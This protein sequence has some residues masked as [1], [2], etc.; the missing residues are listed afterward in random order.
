[1]NDKTSSP[2][3][4]PVISS[5]ITSVNKKLKLNIKRQKALNTPLHKLIKEK[6][7]FLYGFTN[8]L[9]L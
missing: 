6:T 1:M 9:T 8:N 7:N 4:S 2:P 5:I 3:E